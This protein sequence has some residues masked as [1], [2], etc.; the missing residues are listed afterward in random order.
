MSI[1]IASGQAGGIHSLPRTEEGLWPSL[2]VPT[3]D[4][5]VLSAFKWKLSAAHCKFLDP[6]GA[7]SKVKMSSFGCSH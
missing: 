6:G 7:I 1:E 5:K 2:I 4:D 3:V